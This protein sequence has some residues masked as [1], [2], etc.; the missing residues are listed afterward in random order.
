MSR[1]VLEKMVMDYLSWQFPVSVFSWQGGEPTLCGLDFFREAV[2]L[3]MKHGKKGQR[4]ANTIQT[5]GL[6]LN[7]EWCNFFRKYLFFVGISIDG[8][9]AIHDFYRGKEACATVMKKMR[10]LKEHAVEFNALSVL[11]RKSEGKAREIL[12]FFLSNQIRYLQFIPCLE[13]EGKDIASYSITPEGYGNF[14]AELFDLWWKEKQ[15]V[16][17]RIFDSLL[18][19]LLSGEN[20]SFCPLA[21]TCSNY[22]VVE[23][24]GSVYPC[25]FFVKKELYLGNIMQQ[26]IGELYESPG[27]KKFNLQK[28]FL[29]P[30]CETCSYLEFCYGGCQKDRLDEKGAP[31]AKTYFCTSYRIFFSHA[32]PRLKS[33]AREI[34]RRNKK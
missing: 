25:D 12:D 27:K 21:S 16:S 4:V 2:R 22:V 26:G 30:E 19:K 15:R 5:N 1:E 6:L 10:M 31:S 28:R 8:P 17:I 20:H 11:T 13:K 7:K 3:Q 9:P 24:D 29:S 33:Y 14:L 23:Y 34:S 18:E 32:L